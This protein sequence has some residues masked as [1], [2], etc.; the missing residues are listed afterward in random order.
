MR[1]LLCTAALLLAQLVCAQAGSWASHQVAGVTVHVASTADGRLLPSAAAVITRALRDLS[2][3]TELSMCEDP[4]LY[5][6]PDLASYTDATGLPW[7]SLA[8]ADRDACRIDVQRL[9]V[10]VE[11]SGL[12]LTL[13]HELFH[14][15]QP[16]GWARWRAEGEALLFSGEEPLAAPLTGLQPGQ[17]DALLLAPPDQ[18]TMLRAA[19]TAR[20]WVLQGR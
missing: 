15:S 9:A 17:L 3:R 6:H 12:E 16:A 20:A 7:F 1:T 14:L 10:V 11:R 5:V 4:Q 13:R 18:E 8:A 19:A 2:V